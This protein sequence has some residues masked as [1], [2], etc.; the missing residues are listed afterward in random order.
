[1]QPPRGQGC[2]FARL[3]LARRFGHPVET[4]E[5]AH[6]ERMAVVHPDRFAR[7]SAV[8]RRFAA[9]HAAT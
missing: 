5:A 8:E 9:A 1:V 4:I 2:H 6:A 7:A 3:G